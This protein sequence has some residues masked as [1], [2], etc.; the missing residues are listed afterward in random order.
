MNID[1]EK[2]RDV[3]EDMLRYHICESGC[4]EEYLDTIQVHM[5]LLKD[6]GGDVE[7]YSDMFADACADKYED[8][9]SDIPTAGYSVEAALSRADMILGGMSKMLKEYGYPECAKEIDTVLASL[10]DDIQARIDDHIVGL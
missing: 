1:P 2:V 5:A 4:F 8:I 10:K 3:C 9:A 7:Y 6:Y